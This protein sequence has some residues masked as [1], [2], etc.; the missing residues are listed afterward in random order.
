VLICAACVAA[1]TSSG[2]TK[3]KHY[4]G[5]TEAR[6]GEQRGECI[7]KSS[8]IEVDTTLYKACS[9]YV[10]KRGGI[11]VV[12]DAVLTIEPGVEVRFNDGDWLEISADYTQGASIIA[13]GTPEEPIVLTSREPNKLKN[14]TWFGLWINKGTAKGSVVSNVIIRAAGGD[15]R[16][17]KPALVHGCLTVTDIPEGILTLENVHL[18]KCV[19]AGLVLRRSRPALSGLTVMDSSVGVLLDGVPVDFIRPDF[20]RERVAAAI[21]EGP[22]YRPAKK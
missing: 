4:G 2:C 19:N 8:R 20:A 18:E 15:N 14:G 22:S 5:G 11:D 16:L 3:K 1:F 12:Y 7:L 21:L 17:F 10:L 13:R 9:P 6:P